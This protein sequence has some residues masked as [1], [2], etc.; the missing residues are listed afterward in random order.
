MKIFS[1]LA[2]VLVLAACGTG[3]NSMGVSTADVSSYDRAALAV[4][5]SVATYR[6]ATTSMASPS[7]CQAA[8]HQYAAQ[9]QPALDQ[10]K[11]MSSRM[12]GAMKS[13]GQTMRADMECGADVMRG[14]LEQHMS[15]A[16]TA[17]DVEANRAEAARHSDAMEGFSE[18]MRM[19]ASEVGSMM[20][21]MGSGMGMM[22]GSQQADGGWT[23]PDGGTMPWNHAIAGCVTV[24]GGSQSDGGNSTA[25]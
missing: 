1:A 16:C 13:M 22:D 18:H 4:S 9:V 23:M 7:D 10:M 19:R 14:E 11:G 25:N 15:V 20:G 12:D 5:G 24:D 3:N 17:A 21:R 6:A 8:V 2:S